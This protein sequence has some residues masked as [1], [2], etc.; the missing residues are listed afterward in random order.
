M[1]ASGTRARNKRGEGA[2]L[3]DEIVRAATKLLAD[4]TSQ[5]VTLRAVVREA[6]NSAPSIYPH[7]ADL[8][9]IMLAVAQQASRPWNTN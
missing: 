8:D 5:A 7:F 9:A 1:S 2:Q 6:G 4:G 3:R